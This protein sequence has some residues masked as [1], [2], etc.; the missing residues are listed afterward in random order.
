MINKTDFD[1]DNRILLQTE[2][3]DKSLTTGYIDYYNVSFDDPNINSGKI[4]IYYRY[5]RDPLFEL[6]AKE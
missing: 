4:F 2:G 5:N 6:S 3:L 1:N